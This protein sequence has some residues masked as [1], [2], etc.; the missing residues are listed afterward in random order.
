MTALIEHLEHYLGPI[1]HGWK[2][3]FRAR[4]VPFQVAEF[5]LGPVAECST[6]STIGLSKFPLKSRQ[7]GR[8]IR[9]E[10]VMLSRRGSELPGIPGILQQVGTEAIR[11]QSAY[12]RGDVIGPRGPIVEGS[13]LEALYV[14]MPSYFPDGFATCKAIG[15]GTVLFVWL[16]PITRDEGLFAREAGWSSF[17]DHLVSEDPDILDPRR[18]GLRLAGKVN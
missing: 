2:R 17:E 5:A 11:T 6:F 18:P 13:Q 16:V 1:V 8:A 3:D 7:T 9:H 12:L 10:L 4:D 14:T 15:L